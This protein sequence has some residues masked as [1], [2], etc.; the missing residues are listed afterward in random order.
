MPKGLDARKARDFKLGGVGNGPPAC[1]IP[2]QLH[3]GQWISPSRHF[4]RINNVPNTSAQSNIAVALIVFLCMA[5][6]PTTRHVLP[7]SDDRRILSAVQLQ[8]LDPQQKTAHSVSSVAAGSASHGPAEE[9]RERRKRPSIGEDSMHVTSRF[10]LRF[11]AC[12]VP[13]QSKE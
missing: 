13:H 9:T 11:C 2:I 8:P 4:S 12:A 1:G 3:T 7:L 6:P 10:A 5:F